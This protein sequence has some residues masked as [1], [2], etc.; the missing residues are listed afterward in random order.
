MWP[1]SKDHTDIIFEEMNSKFD[2]V[3]E[4]VGQMQSQLKEIPKR[5]EFNELKSDVK[6]IKASVVS[7]SNQLND[8]EKRI[9]RLETSKSH[10]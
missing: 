8:Q 4:A 5:D 3:V 6:I 10:R 9:T 2:H 1:V 7:H